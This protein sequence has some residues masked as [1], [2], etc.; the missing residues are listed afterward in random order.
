LSSLSRSSALSGFRVREFADRLGILIWV[1]GTISSARDLVKIDLSVSHIEWVQ[2]GNPSPLKMTLEVKLS[3]TSNA[4]L[5][6]GRI[7]IAQERLW[8]KD[9][10]GNLELIRVSDPPDEF[11]PPAASDNFGGIHEHELLRRGTKT[12]RVDH[13]VYLAPT[14]LQTS[15]THQTVIASFHITDVR[16]D[17]GASDYWTGPISIA[18]PV[19]CK[20]NN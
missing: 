8:K 17:G 19:D 2:C 14:D 12:I 1:F 6:L 9:S 10:K 16:R 7:E 4:P 3:N 20:V 18:L 11:A 13:H 5:V 15:G